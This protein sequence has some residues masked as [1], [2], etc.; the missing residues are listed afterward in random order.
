MHGCIGFPQI[1][2]KA[3][4]E[5][6]RPTPSLTDSIQC[7]MIRADPAR[8]R[9]PDLDAIIEMLR[10]RREALRSQQQTSRLMLMQAFL[11]HAR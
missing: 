4:S 3:S 7:A 8:I 1:L 5:T 10:G 11:D 2:R 6:S 9:L